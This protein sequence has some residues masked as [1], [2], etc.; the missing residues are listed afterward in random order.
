M[1]Y[2]LGI[3]FNSARNQKTTNCIG[4]EDGFMNLY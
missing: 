1:Q 2:E 4:K 3:G